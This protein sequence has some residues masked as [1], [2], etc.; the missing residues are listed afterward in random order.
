MENTEDSHTLSPL[1][2]D[3]G[4]VSGPEIIAMS[5]VAKHNKDDDC[6]IVV[7][8]IVYDVSDFLDGHPGGKKVLANEGGK[9]ATKKFNLFHDA[10]VMRKYGPRLMVGILEGSKAHKRAMREAKGITGTSEKRARAIEKTLSSMF[11]PAPELSTDVLVRTMPYG[12]L[13]PY[14][15]PS[16]YQTL[17]SPY[18]K[19][20]HV[21]WRFKCRKWMEKH[22]IPFVT[23]WNENYGPE[24][25]YKEVITQMYKDGIMPACVGPPWPARYVGSQGPKDFDAF[26]ELIFIDEMS[27][28]A[29]GGVCW[30]LLG[31]ITIGLPPVINFGS[32]ELKKRIVPDCLSGKK[33]IC[34]CITEPWAGSDVAGLRTT[35]K[36]SECGKYYIVNG[37][38]KWITNGVWA[39]YFT[40]AVRTGGPGAKG[41]SML[42]VEKDMEGV[43]T[44]HMK[45]QGV[46]ASGTTYI[47]FEDVKVPVENLVGKENKG[48][49]YVM[50]NFNHERWSLI[51]QTNR[52]ARVCYEEAFKYATKRKT[53]GRPLIKYQAIR[54]KLGEM[55]RKIE[56]VQ[57]WLETV[58]FQ[59]TTMSKK[60]QNLKLGGLI[61]LL[62]T[63]ASKTFEFCAREAAQIFGGAAYTRGGVGEKVERLYR[64]VRAY[65][66]P[67]GSE[68]IMMDFGTR[69]AAKKFERFSRL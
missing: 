9:D 19:K 14:G 6:W 55:I 18:Y 38:K 66:I 15:D 37:S 4:T 26:H 2:T 40:V 10:G 12:Q 53:F 29:S 48:W 27:R 22:I 46:W 30:G 47:N 13:V 63:H 8:G 50:Y 17:N 11:G 54:M 28:C 44:R 34:L 60:E 67:G 59:L 1:S 24:G 51:V 5:E 42:V 39:D 20:S 52:F 43:T 36:K 3:S 41:I 57:N 65:A 23:K 16:W 7:D 45:C 58:T 64:D 35:A 33:V 32:E 69:E 62:K 68:E 25:G 31:G 56:S 61:A 21:E 49:K